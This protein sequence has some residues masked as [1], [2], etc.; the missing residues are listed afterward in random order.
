M[1]ALVAFNRRWQIGS[2]DLVFV[3]GG[4]LLARLFW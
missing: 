1:P 3:F 4:G 2:D